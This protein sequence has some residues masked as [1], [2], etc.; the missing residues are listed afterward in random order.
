L[1]SGAS[2][3]VRIE[4]ISVVRDSFREEQR[5][6]SLLVVERGLQPQ[7]CCARQ[8]VFCER[9][10]APYI[11]FIDRSDKD[12]VVLPFELERQVL[13][14]ARRHSLISSWLIAPEW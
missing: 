14:E 1:K 2:A 5:L 10:D 4:S 12:V 11:E 9:Q 8:D 6:Q 13:W 7:V 3:A